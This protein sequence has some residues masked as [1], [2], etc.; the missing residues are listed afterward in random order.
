MCWAPQK[1]RVV[2]ILRVAYTQTYCLYQ[3]CSPCLSCG[4]GLRDELKSKQLGDVR[5]SKVLRRQARR[6]ILPSS[7]VLS[8]KGLLGGPS[9][10]CVN[11]STCSA[12]TVYFWRPPRS[13]EALVSPSVTWTTRSPSES[14]SLYITCTQTQE[15]DNTD[16]A[17]YILLQSWHTRCKSTYAE[18]ARP[19]AEG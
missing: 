7:L 12:Y 15:C 4:E 18:S 1:Y 17:V 19:W 8:S 10:I 6:E 3:M 13:T 14:F 11:A 9:P 5:R 2:T 16:N